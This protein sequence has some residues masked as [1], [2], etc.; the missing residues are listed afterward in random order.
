MSPFAFFLLQYTS[1][2]WVYAALMA[3]YGW[4][5]LR[6]MAAHHAAMLLVL[7]HAWRSIGLGSII[8]VATDPALTTTSFAVNQAWGDFLA[9]V[10]SWVAFSALRYRVRG[11]RWLVLVF[12]VEGFY[13]LSRAVVD[14]ILVQ[15]WNFQLGA[16][17]NVITFF[18]PLLFLSHLCLFWLLGTRWAE[19][20][21]AQPSAP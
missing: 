5:R 19:L 21:R 4:P 18:A 7:P 15:F 3:W 1:T 9:A 20:G 2:F 6:G 12:N 13:D 16:F 11:A 8:P 17:W 10:L 14:G